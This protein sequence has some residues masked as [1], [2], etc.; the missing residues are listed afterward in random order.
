MNAFAHNA[1][2]ASGGISQ[3]AA[4]ARYVLKAAGSF[5]G[6]TGAGFRDTS[7]AFDVTQ[8][9]TSSTVLD[10][11]RSITWDVGNANRTIRLLGDFSVRSKDASFSTYIGF[12]AGALA[13]ST[14]TKC[15]AL[16]YKALAAM[17]GGGADSANSAF[18]YR[19]LTAL[20]TGKSNTGVGDGTLFSETTGNGNT[21]IGVH[22]LLM[23]NGGGNNTAIGYNTCDGLT[24]GTNNTAIGY[25]AMG[26]VV[27]GSYN[28]AIGTSA[29]GALTSG[30]YNWGSGD[31]A[32]SNITTGSSNVAIGLVAGFSVSTG[33]NNIFIGQSAGQSVTGSGGVYIGFEA[34]KNETG[35]N[36]LYIDNSST[37]TPL[38]GGDFSANTLQFNGTVTIG[39]AFNLVTGTTTGTVFAAATNQK[40]AFWGATAIVQPAHIADPSGGAIQD[41]ES[42]TAI[43]AINAMLAVTGLTAAA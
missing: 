22:A 24:T 37:T 28:V 12:D 10:A 1:F 30:S 23:Q 5:T 32:L 19:S 11:G 29:C 18:G 36:K 13:L 8:I 7:A 35:S 4:D 6:L 2:A 20:T 42:R 16:G 34:G 27:T 33:S 15:T 31:R 26:A 3:T 17:S 38:I 14:D 43:A 40:M 21:A 9:F 25:N 41:A 39:E